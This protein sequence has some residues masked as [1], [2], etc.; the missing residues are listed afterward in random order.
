MM[1]TL[2]SGVVLSE[3]SLP[4]LVNECKQESAN[5]ATWIDAGDTEQ[6]RDFFMPSRA[7]VPRYIIATTP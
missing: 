7:Q 6:E 5:C 2:A 1:D 3:I 4:V